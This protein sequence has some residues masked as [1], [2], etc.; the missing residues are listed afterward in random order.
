MNIIVLGANG[1]LG[2]TLAKYLQESYSVT[3]I[4]SKDFNVLV[5]SIFDFTRFIQA[6]TELVINCIG[7]IK[8][9][10]KNYT[11]EE[12]FK[13]NSIFP[14]QL[15][16]YLNKYFKHINMIHISTDCVFSGNKGNYKKDDLPDADDIYGIS[17]ILGE[18][19]ACNSTVI[20]TSIIGEEINNKYSLLEWAK[21]QKGKTI[22]GWNNHVW[23]GVTTLELAH[24][25][26]YKIDNLQK[27]LIQ[28][29]STP[30]T[31]Y[32]LLQLINDIYEL[33]LNINKTESAEKCD[34]SLICS[35]ENYFVPSLRLQLIRLKTFFQKYESK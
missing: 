21:S 11:T 6:D 34:R 12:I 14:L 2:N 25:I 1:M 24:Y 26:Q 16:N 18:A 32:E 23:S 4:T 30:I 10:I 17:K 27:G 29:A 8:P 33:N 9:R 22:N 13:V 3:E 5:N 28:L 7:I 35:D 15:S 20:R 31:K 19:C